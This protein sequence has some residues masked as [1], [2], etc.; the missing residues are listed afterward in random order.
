MGMGGMFDRLLCM[1]PFLVLAWMASCEPESTG[2][3]RTAPPE[4]LHFET[5]AIRL[6]VDEFKTAPSKAHEQRVA[7]AFA[8]FDRQVRDLED[9]LQLETEE[10]EAGALRER[11]ADL[12]HRREIHWARFQTRPDPAQEPP[13]R[14]AERVMAHHPP[15]SKKQGRR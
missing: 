15:A 2:P 1:I 5:L 4:S 14:V 12:K 8:A 9:D 10:E 6:A 13:A 11:I 7:Q 3:V